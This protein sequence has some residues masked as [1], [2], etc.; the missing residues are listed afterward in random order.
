VV[1]DTQ[2]TE[3]NG[4][5]VMGNGSFTGNLQI[6]GPAGGMSLPEWDRT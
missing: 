5:V 6:F 1:G 3:A 2:V 4:S